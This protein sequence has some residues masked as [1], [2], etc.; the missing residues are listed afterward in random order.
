VEPGP[1]GVTSVVLAGA[2]GEIGLGPVRPA[3]GGR[4]A[5][6]SER[7]ASRRRA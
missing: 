1:P 6:A 4:A 2:A 5:S 3:G 7:R